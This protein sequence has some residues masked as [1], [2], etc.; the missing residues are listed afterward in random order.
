MWAR[1]HAERRQTDGPLQPKDANPLRRERKRGRAMS[2]AVLSS[3]SQRSMKRPSGNWGSHPTQQTEYRGGGAVPNAPKVDEHDLRALGV[4]TPHNG[5]NTEGGNNPQRRGGAG[6]P[7]HAG[8]D[9]PRLSLGCKQ[10]A[11]Q[12][13]VCRPSCTNSSALAPAASKGAGRSPS[14]RLSSTRT[15]V[16]PSSA[17]R[18]VYRMAL[19]SA[20]APDVVLAEAGAWP[21]A[22]RV[23]LQGYLLN[24]APRMA[25]EAW[26]RP[27]RL[28]RR[29]RLLRFFAIY[30]ETS[31]LTGFLFFING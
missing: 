25:F 20:R 5:L 7:Q 23:V 16:G 30:A 18:L 12:L 22:P 11:L 8:V 19:L 10:G 27:K 1:P 26:L 3:S 24:E 9:E 21:S 14:A 15:L 6:S 28:A 17:Q 29:R 31:P 13:Y 4:P 2:R